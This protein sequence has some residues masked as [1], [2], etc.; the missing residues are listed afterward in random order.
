MNNSKGISLF[1]TVLLIV[2]LLIVFYL[3]GFFLSFQIGS[4]DGVSLAFLCVFLILTSFSLGTLIISLDP[5]FFKNSLSRYVSFVALL[6]SVLTLITSAGTAVFKVIVLIALPALFFHL[7][8]LAVHVANF[9]RERI[10]LR[11]KRI[12][13][14]SE[15]RRYMR[16]KG[17]ATAQY[18]SNGKNWKGLGVYDISASGMRLIMREEMNVGQNIELKIIIPYDTRPIFAR[19]EIIW[20][21]EF[22]LET[23][24]FHIGVRFIKIDSSDVLRL[25][26]KQV[27]SLFQEHVT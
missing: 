24:V 15:K 18:L 4:L 27:Y 7:F 20:K 2:F 23:K 21:R 1:S 10:S 22:L 5:P 9:L 19:G 14:F 16:I 26:L 25:S 17:Y 3:M 12:V 13:D 8:I 6:L 11:P